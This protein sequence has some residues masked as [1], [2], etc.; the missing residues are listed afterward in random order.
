LI[1]TI[2]RLNVKRFTRTALPVILLFAAT[3]A[4][5][6]QCYTDE[7][8]WYAH[9]AYPET[10]DFDAAPVGPLPPG[11]GTLQGVHFAPLNN[12]VLLIEQLGFHHSEFNAL[13]VDDPAVGGNGGVSITFDKAKEGVGIWANDVQFE[14]SSLT[15]YTS[16]GQQLDVKNFDPNKEHQYQFLGCVAEPSDAGPIAKVDVLVNAKTGDRVVFDDLRFAAPCHVHKHGLPW[17]KKTAQRK[18]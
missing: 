16:S 17:G 12:G 11:L 8:K 9:V 1:V 4:N 14:G 10:I 6:V 5:A 3:G 18:K 15:F 7:G 2:E 13:A